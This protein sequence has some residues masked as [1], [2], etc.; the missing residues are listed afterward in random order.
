MERDISG[1][2]L[3]SPMFSVSFVTVSEPFYRVLEAFVIL[4]AILLPTKLP[5][6][7]AGF[8]I[9]FLK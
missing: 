5:D 1:I 4:L 3:S 9:T 6:A 2:F 8:K 7:S